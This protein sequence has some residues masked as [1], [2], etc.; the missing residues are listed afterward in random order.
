MARTAWSSRP[1]RAALAVL[2]VAVVVLVGR[3]VSAELGRTSLDD[4]LGTMPAESLRVSFTDWSAVRGQVGADLGEDPS[5]ESVDRMVAATFDADLGAASAVDSAAGA[6]AELL[7]FGPGTADW[8]VYGQSERGA[9]LAVGMP[10]GSDLDDVAERLRAAGYTE[11]DA[12]D[13]VWVGGIDLVADL[14]PTLSPVVQHVVLLRGQGL[15]VSSDTPSYAEDTAEVAAGDADPVTEVAGVEALADRLEGTLASVL[16][17]DDF[18]CA[19]LAMTR[20]GETEQAQ[21]RDRVEELGGVNPLAG[22]A[23]GLT[24]AG[25][26][27]VVEHFETADRAESDLRARA[28]LASGEAYGRG[29]S[30]A[31]DYELAR[32]RT[33]DSEVVLDL[34][35]RRE[36]TFALSSLFDGPVV[37]ATC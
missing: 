33:V 11:P 3:T 27:R 12:A 24:P 5:R 29:G 34:E 13:G 19:D 2:L 20:A 36:G 28:E 25:T 23:M 1:A 4:A 22:L 15:V 31:D 32:A 21:A 10:R 14:D 6:M 9:A 26:V 37:F 7:G 18:A 16:W 35:P 17:A 8:E 30:F